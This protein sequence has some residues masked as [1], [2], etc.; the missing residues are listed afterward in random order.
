MESD[1][2]QDWANLTKYKN[3][4]FAY[5]LHKKMK[6]ELYSWET[7]S[8]KNGQDSIQITLKK[9]PILIEVLGGSPLPRC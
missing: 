4:N 7:Q 8:L 9:D 2:N 3:Q 6:E 1:S 5:L